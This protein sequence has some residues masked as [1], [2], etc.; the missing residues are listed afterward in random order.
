MTETELQQALESIAHSNLL[1]RLENDV[2][3]RHLARRDPES[4]QSNSL[5]LNLYT[6]KVSFLFNYR[7]AILKLIATLISI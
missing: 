4:L 5:P 2:F 3:E 1:L 7:I 6:F